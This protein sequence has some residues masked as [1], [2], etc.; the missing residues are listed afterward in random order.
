MNRRQLFK[1]AVAALVVAVLPKG[2]RL[3]VPTARVSHSL[4]MPSGPVY[5]MASPTVALIRTPMSEELL[6]DCLY[7][8][9]MMKRVC[10]V[11]ARDAADRMDREIMLS[12][13]GVD[14]SANQQM[15]AVWSS[16]A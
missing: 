10:E 15:E 4:P 9:D 6:K 13:E 5:P 12:W 8:D 11:V 7:R 2:K 1:A 14:L 3:P 16:D